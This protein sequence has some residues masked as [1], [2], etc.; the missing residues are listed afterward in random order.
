MGKKKQANYSKYNSCRNTAM[1]TYEYS[2][3]IQK[4]KKKMNSYLE[5]EMLTSGLLSSPKVLLMFLEPNNNLNKNVSNL[6]L[7]NS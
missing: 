1:Y 7:E 2:V 5:Q 6:F 4:N 3:K